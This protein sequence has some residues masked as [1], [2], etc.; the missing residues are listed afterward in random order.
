MGERVD[1]RGN[2][3][4]PKRQIGRLPRE[5]SP[6]SGLH[7]EDV[8]VAVR[9]VDE[10]VRGRVKQTPVPLLHR[11]DMRAGATGACDRAQREALDV[12][13]G[14][15]GLDDLAVLQH[16]VFDVAGRAQHGQRGEDLVVGVVAVGGEPRVRDG[17]QHREIAHE[18]GDRLVLVAE[19]LVQ[20]RFAAFS[21][22]VDDRLGV[23]VTGEAQIGHR[24]RGLRLVV[25]GESGPALDPVRAG[26]RGDREAYVGGAA[27]RD[28]HG[29]RLRGEFV[30]RGAGGLVALGR[31]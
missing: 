31:L 9:C 20:Q 25:G 3:V 8:T 14:A 2:A 11:R 30:E 18:R 1:R 23:P 15:E 13:V 24:Q 29:L 5:V 19:H 10:A 16:L 12:S 21:W 27:G 17:A 22:R 7:A 6:Q 28:G 26:A 4:Q